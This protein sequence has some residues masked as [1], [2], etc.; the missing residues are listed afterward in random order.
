M[1]LT[2]RTRQIVIGTTLAGTLAAVIWAH[3]QTPDNATTALVAPSKHKKIAAQSSTS[4]GSTLAL[5][6]LHRD[7]NRQNNKIT[8]IFAAKSW[9][10]PPPPPPPS[11]PAP[12]MAPPLPFTYLGQLLQDG[13]LTVFLTSQNQN[14]AAK[15]GDIIDDRYRVDSIA[16]QSM[17]FTYLPL[18]QQQSLAIGNVN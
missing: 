1:T 14:Y 9:Y 8:D 3:Q 7:S 13:Q 15:V 11:R 18:H 10:V 12:P 2:A 17:V 6:K 5:N 16:A 4:D